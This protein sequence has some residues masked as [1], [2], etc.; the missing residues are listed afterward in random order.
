MRTKFLLFDCET[1]GL[2]LRRNLS[3][4]DVSGWP[5]LVQIA[6]EFYDSSGNPEDMQCQII[7]P[8]GFK[9]P[10]ESTRIHGISHSRA[11]REGVDLIQ[12]LDEFSEA[13]ERPDITLVAHNLDFDRGV[14]GAE[15]IRANKKF[16]MLE[17]PALCTM[18]TTTDLCR[19]PRW[20]GPGFKWPT[21]EELHLHL[22]SRSF[23]Q[24]HHAL[25]DLRACARCF[26]RLVEEGYYKFP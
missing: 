12:V 15:L 16:H 6:W 18:K 19:L 2:P 25:N 22:F 1:T 4:W 17:M 13:I 23:E 7:R 11:V 8:D 14:V 9:I 5:R 3:P 24:P 21:L 10:A 20:S 26:F